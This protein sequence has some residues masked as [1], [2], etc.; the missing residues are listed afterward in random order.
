MTG[1]LKKRDQDTDHTEGN[2]VPRGRR[3]TSASQVERSQ[4]KVIQLTPRSHTC[5]LQNCEEINFCYSNCLFKPPGPWCSLTAAL[6]NYIGIQIQF[7]STVV[8]FE[9]FF[10]TK[11]INSFL[12][13]YYFS[14][15]SF[16]AVCFRMLKSCI[17][18]WICLNVK[19]SLQKC[20]ISYVYSRTTTLCQKWPSLKSSQTT[21]NILSNTLF[22]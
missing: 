4:K 8:L 7:K 21:S 17:S 15:W 12:L 20:L 22:I 1:V 19:L 14:H 18:T 6:E 3:G 11:T 2:H 10:K 5:S 13:Y 16:Q 9:G